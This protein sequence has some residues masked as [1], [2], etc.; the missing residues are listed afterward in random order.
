MMAVDYANSSDRNRCAER[1]RSSRRTWLHYRRTRPRW[2]GLWRRTWR[3]RIDRRSSPDQSGA[4]CACLAFKRSWETRERETRVELPRERG[5]EQVRARDG[6]AW[7]R[8]G[9]C[10]QRPDWAGKWRT[11]AGELSHRTVLELRGL[12]L[13]AMTPL[14]TGQATFGSSF[15][16]EVS[17]PWRPETD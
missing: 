9:L 1:H 6:V 12:P 3:T 5:I 4:I 17:T 14:L 7:P 16:G 15:I 10:D 13:T 11:R 2:A 8:C